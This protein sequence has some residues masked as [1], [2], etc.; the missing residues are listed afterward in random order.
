MSDRRLGQGRLAWSSPRQ[1][2][3]EKLL[4]RQQTQILNELMRTD[5][6]YLPL[7]KRR[8]WSTSSHPKSDHRPYNIKPE[9]DLASNHSV[10]YD[11]CIETSKAITRLNNSRSHGERTQCEVLGKDV[12]HKCLRSLDQYCLENSCLIC[13]SNRKV[14][15]C[16]T[17]YMRGES[18]NERRVQFAR[19]GIGNYHLSSVQI[20]NRLRQKN[21]TLANN[22]L[23]MDRR[24]APELKSSKLKYSAHIPT[25]LNAPQSKIS[26]YDYDEEQLEHLSPRKF[27]MS[28]QVVFGAS[29]Q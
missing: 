4:F 1:Q 26:E 21:R 11:S 19:Y 28:V 22:A 10:T 20:F 23:R 25:V 7:Y 17:D 15:F 29:G 12:C 13:L 6:H 9:H 8:F 24:Q 2:V 14:P 27:E 3:D 16:L 5:Q 18:L